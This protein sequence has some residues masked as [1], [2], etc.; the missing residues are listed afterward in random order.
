M[1]ETQAQLAEAVGVSRA[2]LA[3][4]ESGKYLPSERNAAE[5]DRYLGAGNTLVN[6]VEAARSRTT[7][8]PGTSADANIVGPAGALLDVFQRVGSSLV[9]HLSRGA[10]GRP[11]GWRHNLQQRRSQSAGGTAYG[12]K[13]MLVI[14]EPYVDFAAL[15]E[16]LMAMRSPQGN[17]LGRSGTA[18]TEI[19]AAVLDVLSRIGAPMSVDTALKLL[20]ETVGEYSRTRPYLL[21]TALQTALRLR[22]DGPLAG[23]LI[24]DLLATRLELAG[25]LL[26]PEKNEPAMARPEPSLSHTA[27]AVVVLREAMAVLDR[28][29]VRE[30][31]D[32]AVQWIVSRNRP[33][34][35]IAEQLTRPRADGTGWTTVVIRHFTPAWVIQA[36][37]GMPAIPVVRLNTALRSLWERY[38]PQLG[39]WAWGN[40]DLPV[41]MTLDAVTALRAAALATAGPPVSQ[42]MAHNDF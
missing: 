11:L 19:T 20:A 17:W 35:G 38:D 18:R 30:A 42:P 2:N 37:C 31:V 28:D 39:L 4:W 40:G 16:S 10:D 25:A 9:D 13:A 22:P 3:Q 29:D 5:L 33:D 1:R 27:R 34:D 24:D 7:R 23:R 15:V 6:L 8:R 12:I 21:S 32:G 26:W 36:L 41:W 14:G